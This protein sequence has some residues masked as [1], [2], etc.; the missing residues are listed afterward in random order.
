MKKIFIIMLLFAIASCGD[1]NNDEKLPPLKLPKKL[2][3]ADYN[4]DPTGNTGLITSKTTYSDL[5]NIFTKE[6]LL[7]ETRWIEEGTI[8]ENSTVI[9]PEENPLRIIWDEQKLITGFEIEESTSKWNAA[10]IHANMKLS[11]LEK[12]N[13]QPITFYGFEWDEGGKISDFNGGK[14]AGYKDNLRIY[15]NFDYELIDN[16]NMDISKFTGDDKILSS[17]NKDLAKLN[18][19]VDRIEVDY[20]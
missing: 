16:K 2:T 19:T 20:N 6:N 5:V 11:E 15:L 9:M 7:D 10:G 1:N 4:L 8:E 18:I 13:Q 17:E 12:L 14:L 3:T